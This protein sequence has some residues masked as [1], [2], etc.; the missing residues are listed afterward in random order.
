MPVRRLAFWLLL[1][2]SLALAGEK[3]YVFIPSDAKPTA[4]QE[5]LQQTLKGVEV[6]V[7]GRQK[8]FVTMLETQPAAAVI[9]HPELIAQLPGFSIA[10]QGTKGGKGS[11]ALTILSVSAPMKAADLTAEATIGLYDFLG[12][13]DMQKL[14]TQK[15]SVPSKI[16]RVSKLEDLLP[17]L[18]FNMAQALVITQSQVAY[19][20]ATS[21]QQF[22]A[23][24]VPSA[25]VGLMALGTA[26]GASAALVAAVKALPTQT[27][28]LLGV[29]GWK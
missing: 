12:R 17:L 2:A 25:T 23:T 22:H 5:A 21:T 19:F 6:T 13:E 20:K 26:Q 27:K 1:A 3:C 7:F 28:Q 11:E 18:T 29:E 4:I 10:L 16:K 24:E 15:L 14:V 8:D 9:T